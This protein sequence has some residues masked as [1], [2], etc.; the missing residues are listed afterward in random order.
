MATPGYQARERTPATLSEKLDRIAVRLARYPR[1]VGALCVLGTILVGLTDYSVGLATSMAIFYLVPVMIVAF[2]FGRTP[3]LLMA[4]FVAMVNVVA[5][6]LQ[7]SGFGIPLS[8]AVWNSSSR[9]A[10]SAVLAV[11][12]AALRQQWH[13]ERLVARI[14]ATTGVA[15]ARALSERLEESLA[16]ARRNGSVLSVCS[17]DL[18]DFKSVNDLHGHVTGDRLLRDVARAAEGALRPG[19]TVARSGGDEFVLVLP[20]AGE[21]DARAAVDRLVETLKVAAAR[22]GISITLSVGV[23]TSPP[24]IVGADE[25]LR[26]ADE[27]MYDAKRA[28][29]NRTVADSLRDETSP[30]RASRR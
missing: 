10:I 18:D 22:G 3:G 5:D 12:V 24:D 16:A 21:A 9:L 17:F 20:G 27:L 26:K 15:N 30:S 1:T 7:F 29:K 4:S 28:G 19:D 11:V 14:D 8:I 23:L 2:V 13:H 6:G 25:L